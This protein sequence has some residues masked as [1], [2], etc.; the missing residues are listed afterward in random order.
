MDTHTHTQTHSINSIQS[1][2]FKY[3]TYCASPSCHFPDTAVLTLIE[4]SSQKT[5][6]Q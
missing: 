2:S 3:T 4:D 6:Q 1:S 5:E